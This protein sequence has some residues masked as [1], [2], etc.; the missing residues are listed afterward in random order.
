MVTG[1]RQGH[2]DPFSVLCKCSYFLRL[3]DKHPFCLAG[4]CGIWSLCRETRGE[5]GLPWTRAVPDSLEETIEETEPAPEITG[6][7][8]AS[9]L[10]FHF[11]CY[12]YQ[13]LNLGQSVI[14]CFNPCFTTGFNGLGLNGCLQW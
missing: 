2:V 5:A 13:P 9:K 8:N 11:S 14:S 3:L 6:C 4:C 7:E 10:P 12:L 1:K